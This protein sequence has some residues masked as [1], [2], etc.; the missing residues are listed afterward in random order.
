M[1]IQRDKEMSRLYEVEY[2]DRREVWFRLLGVGGGGL[3]LYGYTGWVAALLWSG[4]YLVAQA[5]LYLYLS[6]ERLIVTGRHVTIAGALFLV[7]LASFLWM[8]VHLA[9][10]SDIA[11]AFA[12]SVLLAAVMAFLV[13]RADTL[14]WMVGGEIACIAAAIAWIAQARIKV[15]DG[16]LAIVGALIVGT[17]AVIYVAQAILSA[18]ASRLRAEEAAEQAAQQQKMAAIGRLAGG[19]AHDFNNY[20]AAIIGHLELS[21]VVETDHERDEALDAAHAAA[22]RAERVVRQLLIYARRAPV[23]PSRVDIGE[24]VREAVPLADCLLEDTVTCTLDLPQAPQHVRVDRGQLVAALINL[25]G[26]AA[27]AMPGGG[28][29]TVQVRAETLAAPQALWDGATLAPGRY[30]GIEIRDTGRGIPEPL[31]QKVIEPFFT[32]KP[33]G[34]GTGLGLPMVIGFAR[35]CAGGVTIRTGPDGTAVRLLLPED[36]GGGAAG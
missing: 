33:P 4:I 26:N 13:R 10:E 18:R 14:A 16:S 2:G 29:I 22:K 23:H 9:T 17:A 7:V 8:P 24:A 15:S 1:L 21:R 19:V 30:V 32:T 28:Q 36:E 34:H 12:G 20:L 11:L 31:L 6:R 27:D 3:L 25:L 35:A 5:A